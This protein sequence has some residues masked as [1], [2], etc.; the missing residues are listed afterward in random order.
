MEGVG[1]TFINTLLS[2]PWNRLIYRSE[3][4]KIV[5][6]KLDRMTEELIQSNVIEAVRRKNS[7]D[8]RLVS[9]N[10]FVFK[11]AGG[12]FFPEGRNPEEASFN[13]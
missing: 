1:D 6:R 13:R 3:W 4:K 5:V 12:F 8:T 9:L 2:E 10:P 7:S 11:L